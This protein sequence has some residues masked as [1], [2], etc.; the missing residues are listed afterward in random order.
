M[1]EEVDFVVT[2]EIAEFL[3]QPMTR[4]D[5]I[6]LVQPLRAALIPLVGAAMTSLVILSKDAKSEEDRERV[7]ASYSEIA[8]IFA[9]LDKFDA[10]LVSL[11]DGKHPL[12][13]AESSADE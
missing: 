8:D 4:L 12:N 13:P 3:R 2:P 9:A 10:T 6:H 5:V 1:D 11:L 7:K